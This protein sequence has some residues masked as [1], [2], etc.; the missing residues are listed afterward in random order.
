MLLVEPS[1]TVAILAGENDADSLIARLGAHRNRVMS[2]VGAVEAAYGI[3]RII[4]D[5]ERGTKLVRLFCD[6]MKIEVL[7]L[8][9]DIL[10]DVM[11]AASR[12]GKGTGHPAKLNLGDCFS[13]AF[14]KRL[15]ARI[16]FK[17][18]DFPHTDLDPA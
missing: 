7:P 13:Y 14:A 3:G 16:L 6:E 2:V 9:S 17:G 8:P 1:S 15:G 5:Y 11:L 18:N 10:E 12:Y 4:G